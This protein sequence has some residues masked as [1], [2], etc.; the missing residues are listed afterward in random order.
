MHWKELAFANVVK[1]LSPSSKARPLAKFNYK[2]R[3][4][5]P[6]CP[7]CLQSSSNEKDYSDQQI[8][9][10][11][12][13]KNRQNANYKGAHNCLERSNEPSKKEDQEA[14]RKLDI[15]FPAS[16]LGTSPHRCNEDGDHPNGNPNSH[17]YAHE[18][19]HFHPKALRKVQFVASDRLYPPD[20]QSVFERFAPNG[21]LQFAGRG[22]R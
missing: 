20:E 13:R 21:H 7:S 15:R 6:T 16:A 10:E 17:R 8:V 4:T 19:A 1:E 11:D 3:A 18:F 2:A 12:I 14:S 22:A 5:R 9:S